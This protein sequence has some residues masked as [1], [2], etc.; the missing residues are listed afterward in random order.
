[1]LEF[2]PPLTLI[3]LKTLKLSPKNNTRTKT[4]SLTILSNSWLFLFPKPSLFPSLQPHKLHISPSNLKISSSSSHF[5]SSSST[6][7]QN[8]SPSPLGRPRL[9]HL[10]KGR[11][12]SLNWWI[13]KGIAQNLE[14]V[15]KLGSRGRDL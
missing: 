13:L 4:L 1:M 7:K 9:S 3:S 8:S 12:F 2:E 6:K 14:G 15:F 5:L 10:E 11:D